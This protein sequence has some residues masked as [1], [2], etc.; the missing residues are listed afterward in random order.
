MLSNEVISTETVSML[1]HGILSDI[2]GTRHKDL[3]FWRMV[4]NPLVGVGQM[5]FLK[6]WLNVLF[7]SCF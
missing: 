5:V 7:R 6:K 4:S 2:R 1:S 3:H